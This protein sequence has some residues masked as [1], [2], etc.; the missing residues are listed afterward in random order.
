MITTN[1]SAQSFLRRLGNAAERAVKNAVERNVERKVEQGV[2]KAFDENS[3]KQKEQQQEDTKTTSG[4]TCSCGETG[5]LGNFC[6]ECGN[7]KV[8]DEGWACS[9]G[10]KNNK[11]KFCAECGE[12]MPNKTAIQNTQQ[13]GQSL[14]MTYA[15][16][17]FVAGDE[18]IFEDLL[19]GEQLGEFPSKWDLI[20]GV[21]EIAKLNGEN[22]INFVEDDSRINPL[23]EEA[24]NYLPEIFTVEFD[25]F[26]RSDK[27]ERDN[28]YEDWMNAN[29]YIEFYD[30]NDNRCFQFSFYPYEESWGEEISKGK[31][32]NAYYNWDVSG[33]SRNGDA[34]AVELTTEEW[35]RISISFN[36]RALKLYMDQTRL[37][38]IPNMTAPASFRIATD[39]KAE[40]LYFIK[41]VRIAKGAVPSRRPSGLRK[42]S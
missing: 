41:N 28:G 8:S 32:E 30:A 9:C 29:I 21:V 31:L 5:I 14:E 3:Y 10:K 6:T 34:P 20:S 33:E 38:N 23:M 15:K 26:Y 35:H 13:K 37:F 12:K 25:F 18:I 7:K 16:S 17:D 11:G 19:T 1:F 36:K 2:D 22:T 40:K 27:I 39:E 4:W 42:T 24:K